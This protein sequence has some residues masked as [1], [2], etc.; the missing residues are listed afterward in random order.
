[1]GKSMATRLPTYPSIMFFYT[2]HK[3]KNLGRINF[4]IWE[5]KCLPTHLFVNTPTKKNKSNQLPSIFFQPQLPIFLR[6]SYRSQLPTHP[7]H[8]IYPPS[9]FPSPS[10]EV[11]GCSPRSP[12]FVRK[13][14]PH[15]RAPERWCEPGTTVTLTP[16]VPNKI[17]LKMVEKC[18]KNIYPQKMVGSRFFLIQ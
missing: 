6:P 14:W 1:M 17:L 15:P 5:N 3:K 12:A 2:C 10:T 16:S 4:Y 7:I 18:E 8:P 11:D 13:Q 9:N